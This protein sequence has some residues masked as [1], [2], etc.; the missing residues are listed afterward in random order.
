VIHVESAV[1]TDVLRSLPPFKDAQPGIDRSQFFANF[2]TSKQDLRLEFTDPDDLALARRL[3][4][5]ADVVVESFTPGTLARYGLDYPTLSAERSDLVMLSTCMRGQTGPERHY[6]GFGNQGAA[7]AGLAAITGWP[8]R[9][10]AGPWGAYTDFITPRYGVAALT[11]ALIHRD[12]TGLGQYIDLSQI[13]AGI[14]FE[15]P[16][17]LDHAVNGVIA[18][19]AGNASRYACPHGTYRTR[20]EERFIAIGVATPDQWHA[21]ARL[22]PFSPRS[23]DLGALEARIAQRDL[24]EAE[25][26]AWCLDHDVFELAEQLQRAG[27]PSYPVLRPTDL[28]ADPQLKHRQ[29]FVTLDHPEMGPTPYDGPVTLFSRTPARLRSPGPLLGQ[30]SDEIRKWLSA[31]P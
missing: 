12:A 2:N 11:A 21:L 16:L 29:F 3:A 28:F 30:H 14:Q 8:D 6:T 9:P 18:K 10:P 22:V 5:W 17:L 24:L 26:A 25:L 23:G 27:V 4:D 20:G 31:L 1:R 15:A 13:E 19:A 7:L